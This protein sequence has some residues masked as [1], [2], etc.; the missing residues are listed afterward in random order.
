MMT[1]HKENLLAK[2]ELLRVNIFLHVLV[3]WRASHF[4]NIVYFKIGSLPATVKDPI[5]NTRMNFLFQN[6]PT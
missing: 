3:F 4:D 1:T 5:C 6:H 2:H